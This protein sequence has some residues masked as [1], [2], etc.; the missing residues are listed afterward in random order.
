MENIGAA[1]LIVLVIICGIAG[2]LYGSYMRFK[3]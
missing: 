3:D 2:K 1:A